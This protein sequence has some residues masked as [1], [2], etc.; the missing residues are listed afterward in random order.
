MIFLIIRKRRRSSKFFEKFSIRNL[1]LILEINAIRV[2]GYSLIL[3]EARTWLR[4]I[5]FYVS[6]LL[7]CTVLK[8]SSVKRRMEKVWN[9]GTISISY[10]KKNINCFECTLKNFKSSF[11]KR[12]HI[13]HKIYLRSINLS[14]SFFFFVN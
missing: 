4:E 6:L 7:C 11:S 5:E 3:E 9:Y 12:L 2:L 14:T 13:E 1:K 8:I 10:K